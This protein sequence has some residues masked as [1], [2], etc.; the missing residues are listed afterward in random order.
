MSVVLV[1]HRRLRDRDSTLWRKRPLT[2][3]LNTEVGV[4]H[5]RDPC[6]SSSQRAAE[7]AHPRGERAASRTQRDATWITQSACSTSSSAMLQLHR[8]ARPPIAHRET[9]RTL[10]RL[11]QE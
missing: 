4:V 8:A 3:R 9:L 1:H 10:P 2:L 11:F 6:S 5:R 7:N